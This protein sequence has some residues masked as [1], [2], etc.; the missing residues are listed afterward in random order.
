MRRSLSLGIALTICF[1][2]AGCGDTH[3]SITQEM[4]AKFQELNT[5]LDGVKDE[6]GAKAAA[7]KVESIATEIKDIQ[8]R[9]TKL[10]K[11]SDADQKAMRDK[12][13]KQMTDTMAK[14]MQNA[15][16]IQM[17]P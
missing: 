7:P 6:A 5:V 11:P 12:Y 14:L 9:G 8:N 17:N 10:G 1:L 2:L 3:E 16:R 13:E 4:L 15:M